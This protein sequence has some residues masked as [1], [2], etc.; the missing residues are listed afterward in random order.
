MLYRPKHTHLSL[1]LTVSLFLSACDVVS[2]YGITAD[3]T[4]LRSSHNYNGKVCL[5]E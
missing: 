2:Q 1:S 5:V 3:L 4:S